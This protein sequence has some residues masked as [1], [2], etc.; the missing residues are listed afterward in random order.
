MRRNAMLLALAAA[1]FPPVAPAQLAGQVTPQHE[2]VPQNRPATKS[3][4]IRG[5]GFRRNGPG[6]TTAQVKRSSA[7]RRNVLRSRGHHRQAV[8]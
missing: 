5:R 2:R 8:R 4:V 1:M 3:A 6:W 7:K